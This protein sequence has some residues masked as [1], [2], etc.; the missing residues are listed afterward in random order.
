M[1][2]AQLCPW[3]QWFLL[4]DSRPSEM[5]FQSR[6]QY[7]GDKVLSGA[8]CLVPEQSSCRNIE[9][10]PGRA[11]SCRETL[12]APVQWVLTPPHTAALGP[13]HTEREKSP[14]ARVAMCPLAV[15]GH[16]PVLQ[17]PS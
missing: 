4:A 9:H 8:G 7:P 3:V 2:K 17:G 15:P 11:G 5:P 14:N 13:V 10:V 12:G 1:M 16:F 6:F